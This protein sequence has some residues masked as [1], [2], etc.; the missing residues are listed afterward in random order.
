MPLDVPPGA[1]TMLIRRSSFERAGLSRTE[2][3]AAFNLTPDEFG[4]EGEI[5]AIGPLYEDEAL[6]VLTERLERSGLAYFDD[7]YEL[8]GRWPSWLRVLV[9]GATR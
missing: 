9:M 6:G 5:I 2:L 1:P 7:F 4:V 8:P 3:D